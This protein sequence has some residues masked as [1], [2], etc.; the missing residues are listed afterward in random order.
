MIELIKVSKNSN[1]SAV[2]GSIANIMRNQTSLNVQTVGAGA[3]S[4]I[5]I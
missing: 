2:A 1:V 4:L 3:L 5:H